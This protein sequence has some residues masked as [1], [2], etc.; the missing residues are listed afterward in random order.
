MKKILYPGC[1]LFIIGTSLSCK[2]FLEEVPK[3]SQSVDA[4]YQT[5]D[6]VQSAVNYLYNPASGPGT[7]YNVGGLYDANNAMAFDGMSGLANNVVAQNP[8]VREFTSLTQT[9]DNLG[10]YVQGIW[11][12]LSNTI[13]SPDTII[14]KTKINT[15]LDATDVAPLVATAR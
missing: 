3:S 13:A 9:S 1:I 4:Y 8:S 15:K 5:I 6:Q 14:A 11:A 2:K 10:N 7:F 12:S